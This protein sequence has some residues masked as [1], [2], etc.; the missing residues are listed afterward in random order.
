MYITAS[1]NFLAKR[2]ALFVQWWDYGFW[3]NGLGDA[4]ETKHNREDER[5]N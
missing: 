3:Q 4:R 2:E 5:N 1:I